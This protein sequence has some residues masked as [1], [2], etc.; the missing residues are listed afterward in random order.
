MMRLF[1]ILFCALKV[2][3]SQKYNAIS[4]LTCSNPSTIIE[5]NFNLHNSKNLFQNSSVS[6]LFDEIHSLSSLNSSICA[7][8]IINF[9]E[10]IKNLS[11]HDLQ[12]WY[13]Y[14]LFLLN[15]FNMF[16]HFDLNVVIQKIKQNVLNKI[17]RFF[18]WIIFKK[19][20]LSYNRLKVY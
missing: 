14:F 2:C 18:F 1:I 20:I 16:Y 3:V 8:K 4:P 17:S 19:S 13:I 5:R 10:N 11:K 15:I 12:G 6:T 7:E 9:V